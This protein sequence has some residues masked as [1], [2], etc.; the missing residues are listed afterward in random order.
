MSV[1]L[2]VCEVLIVEGLEIRFD[3]GV[4]DGGGGGRE[5]AEE[6]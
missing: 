4:G 1:G 5:F 2:Y 6:S 3:G